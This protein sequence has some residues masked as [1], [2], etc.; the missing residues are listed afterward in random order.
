MSI[1]VILAFSAGNLT[2]C[3]GWQPEPQARMACCAKGDRSRNVTQ[4]DADDCCAGA[5][6]RTQT[7]GGGA[8]S[9]TLTVASLPLVATAILPAAVPA[10]HHWRTQAPHPVAPVPRHLLLTVLLV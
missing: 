6:D 9:S 8:T 1:A 5:T 7:P 4:A 10:L 3:A 2:L